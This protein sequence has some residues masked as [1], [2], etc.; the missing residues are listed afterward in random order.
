[1][2][3]NQPSFLESGN[4]QHWPQPLTVTGWLSSFLHL[5]TG[6]TL[7]VIAVSL[8]ALLVLIHSAGPKH[9]QSTDQS[10]DLVIRE[11]QC[12]TRSSMS[13]HILRHFW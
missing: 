7:A 11:H 9:H 12:I 10:V 1:L 3:F 8:L 2:S 4:S 6:S 13:H 5:S